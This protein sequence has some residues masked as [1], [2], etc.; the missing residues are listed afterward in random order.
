M[1][2]RDSPRRSPACRALPARCARPQPPCGSLLRPSAGCQVHS[3]REQG[4][5]G[6]VLALADGENQR[7]EKRRLSMAAKQR[8]VTPTWRTAPEGQLRFVV[9][10][11]AQPAP[12]GRSWRLTVEQQAEQTAIDAIMTLDVA[13]VT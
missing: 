11:K 13:E 4:G 3:E 10:Q 12:G 5:A 1:G 2:G 7:I 9:A 8:G 6:G